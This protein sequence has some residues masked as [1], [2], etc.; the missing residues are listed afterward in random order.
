MQEQLVQISL[1]QIRA[2][3][4][5]DSAEEAKLCLSESEQ[6]LAK[7][8]KMKDSPEATKSIST[9]F[10]I[11]RSSAANFERQTNSKLLSALNCR[12]LILQHHHLQPSLE[13]HVL[14]AELSRSCL[15]YAAS[16][17][18]KAV[19]AN[20]LWK[21]FD[22]LFSS[23]TEDT[24]SAIQHKDHIFFI[25]CI[26]FN[27]FLK[28]NKTPLCSKLFTALQKVK[29]PGLYTCCIQVGY[30]SACLLSS[31]TSE[32]MTKCATSLTAMINGAR[33]FLGNNHPTHM[34]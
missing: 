11:I 10:S 14:A 29:F 34:L 22:D 30:L 18:D 1:L 21:F 33:K 3:G 23:L 4:A 13:A 25:A 19:A 20:D 8:Q 7:L 32:T 9:L 15:L 28:L 5:G 6:C 12:K 27:I 17:S 26:S 24:D 2:W 31:T 16:M